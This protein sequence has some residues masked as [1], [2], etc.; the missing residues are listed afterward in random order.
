MQ[1][2]LKHNPGSTQM[3]LDDD[4]DAIEVIQGMSGMRM[5]SASSDEEDSDSSS[6]YRRSGGVL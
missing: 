5:R 4:D 2:P 6:Y 3:I 1:S